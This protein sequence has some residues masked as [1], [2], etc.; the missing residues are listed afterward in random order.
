MTINSQIV[1]DILIAIGLIGGTL[2][3]YRSRVPQ[4]N[5]KNLQVLTDTYEK[6]IKALEEELHESRQAA[7]DNAKAIAD[8]Q[9]QIKVYKE[10]PLQELADGIKKIG[11]SNQMILTTLQASAFISPKDGMEATIKTGLS[12]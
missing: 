6:R 2:V 9:G 12:K 1:Q 11:D 10:L 3:Y 5:I 4:Q 8:L 7:V